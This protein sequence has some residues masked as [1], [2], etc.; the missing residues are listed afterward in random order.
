[1]ILILVQLNA[2]EAIAKTKIAIDPLP[3]IGIKSPLF[4]LAQQV[5]IHFKKEDEPK[6]FAG[7]RA[8]SGG[9]LNGK[10]KG[11]EKYSV[12]TC[13]QGKSSSHSA[14]LVRH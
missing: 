9:I 1:M 2:L 8:R 7:K 13:G 14:W 6:G 10:G 4:S 11:K 12:V 3:M 5:V